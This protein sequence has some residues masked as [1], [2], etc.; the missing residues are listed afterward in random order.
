MVTN[1]KRI[2]IIGNC[3]SGKSYF[4]KKL[5]DKT[6]LPLVHLDKIYWLGNR[7]TVSRSEFDDLLQA[8]LNKEEWIIDGNYHRTIRHR[9]DY[10][11]TVFYFD[12][13][14]RICLKGVISRTY[15]NRG[16]TRD[17]MSEN[18]PERFDLMFL[19]L[20]KNV[21]SFNR[22]H[23]KY[24][25]RLLRLTDNVDVH[26]FKSREEAQKFIDNIKETV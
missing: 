1:M 7:E 21:L 5:A 8:E 22:K 11:D 25:H 16:K 19:K 13:P 18:R 24:Y 4:A 9:L 23:R 20:C 2:I 15:K 14:T 6:N 12:I 10:C 26:I 3:G 17:D